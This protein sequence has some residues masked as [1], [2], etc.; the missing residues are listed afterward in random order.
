MTRVELAKMDRRPMSS[1]EASFMR[2]DV[3]GWGIPTLLQWRKTSCFHAL[4][5]SLPNDAMRAGTD[6]EG[7]IVITPVLSPSPTFKNVKNYVQ[8]FQTVHE[9][10]GRLIKPVS[11]IYLDFQN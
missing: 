1:K 7:S 3:V 4:M 10:R 8:G 11:V 5:T 9:S 2:Q 6:L